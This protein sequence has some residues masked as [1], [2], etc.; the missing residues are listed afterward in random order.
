MNNLIISAIFRR[1]VTSIALV[2]ILN[3]DI[4]AM[5]D[6]QAVASKKRS[7]SYMHAHELAGRLHSKADFI[8]YLD[9]HRKCNI[10][11]ILTPL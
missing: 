8:V 6:P 11:S 4:F 10:Y 2:H 1:I 9:K 5:V 7:L 3:Q